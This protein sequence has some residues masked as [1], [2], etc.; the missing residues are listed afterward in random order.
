MKHLP[1]SLFVTCLANLSQTTSGF[2]SSSLLRSSTSNP[3]PSRPKIATSLSTIATAETHNSTSSSFV[4]PS[5]TDNENNEEDE[6]TIPTTSGIAAD[7]VPGNTQTIFL[8]SDNTGTLVKAAIQASLGQLSYGDN[9]ETNNS[10]QLGNVQTR[11]FTFVRSEEALASII[12]NAKEKGAMVVFTLVD[13]ELREKTLRMC[14]LSNVVAVD[15]L[16]PTLMTMSDYL[17]KAP[18][19]LPQS[20]FI[21]QEKS[22]QR[23][24]ALSDSYFR[25]IEAVEF[26]LK[27]DD[28][29][30]PWLLKDAEIIIVGVSRTGKTPLSVLLSQTQG[31]K[32]ANIPLVLECPP[33]KELFD[34]SKIDPRRVFCLSI[35]PTVLR[36]IRSSRLERRN[37]RALEDKYS[38]IEESS[39]AKSNYADRNYI[40]KDLKH[41][42]DL[43]MEHGWTQ[44]DVTGRAVEETA[45]KCAFEYKG[46]LK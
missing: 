19:G 20:K 29:Q 18:A 10:K 22:Q 25:R 46:I 27:A 31:L 11:V 30:S 24:V 41:V 12:K 26:T 3:L 2:F 43:S 36:Q 23:R 15:L 39:K 4:F 14:E 9:D 16:G 17:G 21:E 28:G 1:L 34:V 33:P 44:I 35:A 40:M 45:R 6:V 13:L 8:I 5:T 37:V 7:I 42:R 32:V 38:L